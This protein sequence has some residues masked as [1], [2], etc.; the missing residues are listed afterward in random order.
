MTTF[1]TL[2]TAQY[3]NSLNMARIEQ[4]LTDILLALP[5]NPKINRINDRC[6]TISNKDL[7]PDLCLTP[8][9]YD[10]KKQYKLIVEII[11]DEGATRAQSLVQEIIAKGS[12]RY[13]S[14]VTRFH[15]GVVERLKALMG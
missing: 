14:K 5:D 1:N 3:L 12:V 4:E 11:E 13:C 2:V 6:F 15:P 9:Y 10:F 8:A 7:S